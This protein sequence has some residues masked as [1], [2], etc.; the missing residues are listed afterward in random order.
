MRAYRVYLGLDFAGSLTGALAFTVA[1][2]YF[3]REAHFSPLQLVLNG[4]V[5]ELTYFVLGV[6][7]DK[8]EQIFE[9]FSRAHGTKYGGLGLGLSITLGI[10][11]QHGGKI[12]VESTGVTGEGSVFHVQLPKD[13]PRN[14]TGRRSATE[15]ET[16]RTTGP[17]RLACGT[18]LP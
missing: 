10:V 14:V 9:R 1:A 15:I 8:K 6:P 7:P 11:Q 18:A 2:V 4:T 12:W 17:R 16:R 5:M 13:P 3:V